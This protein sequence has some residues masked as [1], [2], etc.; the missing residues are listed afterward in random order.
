[1]VVE[2]DMAVLLLCFTA[3]FTLVFS[4]LDPARLSRTHRHVADSGEYTP[5]RR[6]LYPETSTLSP[7]KPSPP[8]TSSHTSCSNYLTLVYRTQSAFS[9][10]PLSYTQTSL[11]SLIPM[12]ISQLST[13][14]VYGDSLDLTPVSVLFNSQ[15]SRTQRIQNLAYALI[16]AG[17]RPGD[18]VAILAPN[19]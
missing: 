16:Q 12:L 11:P 4:L 10:M 15:C 3:L 13:H 19:S 5:P 17:I 2:D 9:C 14:T 8:R 1:M 7:D 6:Q 18:H